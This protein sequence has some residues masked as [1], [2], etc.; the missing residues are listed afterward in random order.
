MKQD[1]LCRFRYFGVPDEVDY[2]NISWRKSASPAPWPSAS[3][4]DTPT[5]WPTSSGSRACAPWPS[6]RATPPP[7]FVSYELE[8][9][10]ILRGLIRVTTDR[11]E[12]L[13]RY[14]EEFVEL[15]G[16]RPRALGAFHEGYNPRAARATHG[17]WL[18]FVGTL[19]GL[20]AGQQGAFERH[21]PLLGELEDTPMTKSY[22]I[23][24][25]QQ[26]HLRSRFLEQST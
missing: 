19:G 18:G 14:Y 4:S 3:H 20:D 16:V 15:H 23:L 22:K 26:F 2:R 9:I 17:S 12:A 1:L 5:S 6:T 11:Q 7:H 25:R 24:V 8:T 21:R 13:K 10:D